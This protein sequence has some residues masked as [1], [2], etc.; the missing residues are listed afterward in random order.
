MDFKTIEHN[1][2]IAQE[3]AKKYSSGK[4]ISASRARKALLDVKKESDKLRKVILSDVKSKKTPVTPQPTATVT[5]DLVEP[6]K[7]VIEP[8]SSTV[9]KK[10][11]VQ[12]KK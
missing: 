10:V 8:I 7:P 4:K 5:P 12:K 9:E 3:E 1:L 6:V 11:K 2:L